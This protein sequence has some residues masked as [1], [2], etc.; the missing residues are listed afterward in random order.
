[1]AYRWAVLRGLARG[2]GVGRNEQNRWLWSV[3]AVVAALSS[4]CA[5]VGGVTASSP[6]EVKEKAAM[7][8]ANAR[9]QAVIAGRPDDAYAFLSSGS[10]AVTT[11]DAYKKQARLTGF[12]T[13]DVKSAVCEEQ[14][15]KVTVDIILDHR[16]MKGIP[17]QLSESWVLENGEYWYVW[18][19]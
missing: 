16:V 18:R 15:C 5:S 9:W 11:L 13:A 12:R 3:V 10:K 19:L 1:M 4:G 17:Y 7:Q 6:P 14:V 8:R 2:R